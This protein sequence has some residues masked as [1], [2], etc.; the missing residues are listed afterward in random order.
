M[1]PYA[2]EWDEQKIFPVETLRAAGALGFCGMYCPEQLGGTGLS[3]MDAAL[4]LEELAQGAR[5]QRPI[6]RSTIWPLGWSPPGDQ[7]MYKSSGWVTWQRSQVCFLLLNGS[8]RWF[9]CGIYQNF[10][11]AVRRPLC[12]QRSQGIYQRRRRH[13]CIGRRRAP[14]GQVLA[15]SVHLSCP[16]HARGKLW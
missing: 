9:R 6:Y 15:A 14:V 4:L 3:R 12:H 2:A 10:G 8:Q 1:A 16:G 7:Q 13:R 5:P 11:A